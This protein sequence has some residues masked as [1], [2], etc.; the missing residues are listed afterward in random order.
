MKQGALI[1]A[2]H[3]EEVVPAS[4]YRAVEAHLRDLQRLLGKKAMEN[5]L[6]REAM[7]QA[8]GLKTFVALGLVAWGGPVIKV[9]EA[10][11][12]AR[13]H[14]STMHKCPS[15]RPR[16]RPPLPDADIGF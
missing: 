1:A 8:A 15:L 9:V 14:L 13:P 11:S 16:G 2:T 6:R 5:E 7:S 10:L 4:E 12:I 3:G